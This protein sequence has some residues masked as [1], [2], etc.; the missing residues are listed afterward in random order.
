[1]R[2][3]APIAKEETSNGN[4]PFANLQISNIDNF[5]F[6]VKRF[7]LFLLFQRRVALEP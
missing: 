4:L 3:A 5:W 2:H 6:V 1:M 7:F